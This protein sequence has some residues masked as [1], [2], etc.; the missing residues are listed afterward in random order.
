M[1]NETKTEKPLEIRLA[2]AMLDVIY[3]PNPKATIRIQSLEEFQEEDRPPRDLREEWVDGFTNVLIYGQT[4]NDDDNPFD[5]TFKP[6]VKAYNAYR[7]GALAAE[8]FKKAKT[9]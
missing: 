7:D 8:S 1:S 3:P 4:S 2:R 5:Q 9:R 6:E